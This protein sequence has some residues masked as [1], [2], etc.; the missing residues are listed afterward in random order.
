MKMDQIA[1]AVSSEPQA[2]IVMAH[3]GLQEEPWIEDIVTCRSWVQGSGHE[4][5]ANVAQLRFNYSMG[6]EFEIIRW[7]EGPNWHLRSPWYGLGNPFISHIG[8]HLD[9]GEDWPPDTNTCKLVQKTFTTS[10]TNPAYS[11][12]K[13]PLYGRQ[14]AYRIYSFS[15][16]TYIKYIKRLPPPTEKG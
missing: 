13:S 12:P 11:D 2:A 9:L 8:V 7:L 4:E 5:H 6:T 16:G 14:Y 10:H 15:P 1:I 3:F